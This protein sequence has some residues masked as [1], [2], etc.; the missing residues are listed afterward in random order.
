[1]GRR[2][3]GAPHGFRSAH[4]SVDPLLPRGGSHRR[5]QRPPPG[6]FCRR[7]LPVAPPGA[8]ASFRRRRRRSA[9]RRGDP[10]EER[11][12]ARGR[13]GDHAGSDQRGRRRPAPAL[14]IGE[15]TP[16]RDGGCTQPAPG[17][18]RAPHRL[19]LGHSQSLRRALLRKVLRCG[20][21]AQPGLRA[22]V[23]DLAGHRLADV[24][25]GGLGTV[26]VAGPPRLPG[27]GSQSTPAPHGPSGPRRGNARGGGLVR[28]FT[29]PG[30]G[31]LCRSHLESNPS[32]SR[33]AWLHPA[34]AG[35]PE[36][37]SDGRPEAKLHLN[38]ES[39]G[40]AARRAGRAAAGCSRSPRPPG[41]ERG[42]RGPCRG[43]C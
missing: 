17:C 16:A 35:H 42:H 36:D 41:R 33:R 38:R 43:R 29:G 19:A 2:A 6:L 22:R 8:S 12:T 3:R 4:G 26:L 23:L 15:S 11:R 7:G 27:R 1:M 13:G 5:L 10:D 18:F 24:Q 31:L 14:E 37:P 25:P 32:A 21:R 9:A 40:R 28:L 39:A 34:G 20:F 30:G